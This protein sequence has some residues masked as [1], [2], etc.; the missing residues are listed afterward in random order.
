MPVSWGDPKPV[1]DRRF[2]RGVANALLLEGAL[3][4]L[5]IGF[6]CAGCAGPTAPR[7]EKPATGTVPTIVH[8]TIHWCPR[9][10]T[11]RALPPLNRPAVDVCDSVCLSKIGGK[12]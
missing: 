1:V 11:D 4:V 10:S 8:G 12:P 5:L 3:A 2:F 6:L 9:D 7:H